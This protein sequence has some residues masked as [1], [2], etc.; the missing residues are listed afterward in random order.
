MRISKDISDATRLF[1]RDA[2]NF[3]KRTLRKVQFRTKKNPFR[4]SMQ[5]FI[6]QTF[7]LLRRAM[8]MAGKK[9]ATK[10]NAEP[11]KAQ[12]LVRLSKSCCVLL[13]H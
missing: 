8:K 7:S 10:L 12:L 2:S 13:P 1:P 5:N 3:S 9:N 11:A 6:L 4:S